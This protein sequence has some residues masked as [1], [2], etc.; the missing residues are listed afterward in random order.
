MVRGDKSCLI[1][2]DF[3]LVFCYR[4]Q[5]VNGGIGPAKAQ[6]LSLAK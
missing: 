4:M 6:V 2:I 3:S 1:S 5:E